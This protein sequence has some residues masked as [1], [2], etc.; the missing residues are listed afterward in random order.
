M[1]MDSQNL[2]LFNVQT[3]IWDRLAKIGIG[4]MSWSKDSKYLYFDT[5]GTAPSVVRIGLRDRAIE[6]VVDLGAL[7]R[8]W[9]RYG[10]WLGLGPDDAPLASRDAGI[11]EIYAAQ[12]SVSK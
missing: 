3:K 10:P 2:L 7:R 1:T 9:G 12:W 5:F 6:K 11:Q 4:Y 8:T